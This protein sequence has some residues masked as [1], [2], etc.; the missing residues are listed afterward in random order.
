[1]T[2]TLFRYQKGL[3]GAIPVSFLA[4]TAMIVMLALM[5][6]TALATSPTVL[7]F[8]D[9]PGWYNLTSGGYAGLTWEHGNVAADSGN[10]GYWLTSDPAANGRAYSQPR[11]VIDGWACTQIGIGFPSEVDLSGCYIAVQGNA[12]DLWATSLRVHGYL[13]GQEVGTTDWFTNISI[14]P[15]WFDMSALPNVDRIVFESACA[16]PGVGGFGLDDL[17]FT[18]VPEPAGVAALGFAAAALLGRRHHRRADGDEG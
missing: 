10:T 5:P 16:T 18:Y 1:V 17:T 12:S 6:R 8:D 4:H 2:T 3:L 14:T 9:L 13:A 15:A 7:N 11:T